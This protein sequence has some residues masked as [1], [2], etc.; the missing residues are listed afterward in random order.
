MTSGSD[1]AEAP[2]GRSLVPSARLTGVVL[3]GGRS[4]RMGR[5]KAL[6]AYAGEPLIHRVACRL[7]PLC[8]RVLIAAGRRGRL[9]DLPW[10]Q[11]D[12]AVPDSGPIG[13]VVAGLQAATT[14][15]VALVGV[16][17][18]DVDVRVLGRL[19]VTW[20]GQDAVVPVVAGRIQPL[21]AIYHVGAAPRLGAALA[22][23][24]RAL[25]EVVTDLDVELVEEAGWSDLD[26]V[27]RFARN[28]NAPHD[29]VPW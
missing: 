7:E 8:G 2:V 23:G 6:L 15:L 17:M 28:L 26:P 1:R 3:A 13:G 25:T 22:A 4:R 5:D 10:E 9:G 18:P 16:D 29:L 14:P 24:R 27:G 21:H 19:A 20:A 12:D 11:V